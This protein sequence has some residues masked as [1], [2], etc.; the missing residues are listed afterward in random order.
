[1]FGAREELDVE[2]FSELLARVNLPIGNLLSRV[3]AGEGGTPLRQNSISDVAGPAT[4]VASA[5]QL[6][7]RVWDDNGARIFGA[8]YMAANLALF[9]AVL[10]SRRGWLPGTTAVAQGAAGGVWIDIARALGM[11]CNLNC[12]FVLVAPR[13]APGH[14]RAVRQGH[15]AAG[16]RGASA[17]ERRVAERARALWAQVPMMRSLMTRLQETWLN[18]WIPFEKVRAPPTRPALFGARASPGLAW[19]GWR[20]RQLSSLLW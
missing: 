11:L 7:G 14:P 17:A 2:G 8:V 16:L 6:A 15:C 4:L 5:R 12:S 20:L 10:I 13:P 18:H 9:L 1:V 3:R 19:A